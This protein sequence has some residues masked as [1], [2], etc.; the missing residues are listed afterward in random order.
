[1]TRADYIL[2]A[3]AAFIV[4]VVIPNALR[5]EQVYQENQAKLAPF[6]RRAR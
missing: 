6:E 1:M 2:L 3:V 4:V 5:K